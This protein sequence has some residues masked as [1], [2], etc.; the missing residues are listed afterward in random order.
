MLQQRLQTKPVQPVARRWL[1]VPPPQVSKDHR[2]AGARGGEPQRREIA[3][4]APWCCEA[5]HSIKT[6][7][8]RCAGELTAEELVRV[9]PVPR[10]SELLLQQQGWRPVQLS[11]ADR[12]PEVALS[13]DRLSATSAKGFR[14]VRFPGLQM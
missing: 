8:A 4:A 12:A 1:T 10:R 13:E 5:E 7:Q 6:R 14:M 3:A 2:G 9:V 11:K